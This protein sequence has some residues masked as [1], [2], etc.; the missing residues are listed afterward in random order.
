[1]ATRKLSTIGI[2]DIHKQKK[3][4]KPSDDSLEL[5]IV[6]DCPRH[7]SVEAV[8]VNGL[9]ITFVG[10]IENIHTL[11][12]RMKIQHFNNCTYHPYSFKLLLV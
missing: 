3:E 1:L 11:I 6:A 9:L 10:C 5:L 12:H 2:A 7:A 4:R 8:Y